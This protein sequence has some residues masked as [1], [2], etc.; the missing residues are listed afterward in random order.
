M[1]CRLSALSRAGITREV[2]ST[3][4]TCKVASGAFVIAVYASFEQ[5]AGFGRELL[6]EQVLKAPLRRCEIRNAV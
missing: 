2:N 5:F 4:R 6:Y 3:A 1:E